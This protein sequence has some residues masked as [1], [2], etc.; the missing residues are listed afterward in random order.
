[1]TPNQIETMIDRIVA[2]FPASQIPRN[3]IKTGWVQDDFLLQADVMEG[4]KALD[5][6]RDSVVKFPSLKE[7]HGAFL[8]ARGTR[9]QEVTNTGCEI[10]EGSG[11]DNGITPTTPLG[12]R[13]TFNGHEYSYVK[14]CRCNSI[15]G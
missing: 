8:R 3:T 1:M 4:R 2:L 7:V 15:T 12:Y 11:W 5:I 6:L 9:T 13:Q 14:K 10:C